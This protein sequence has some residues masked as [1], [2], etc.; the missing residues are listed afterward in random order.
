MEGRGILTNLADDSEK[1]FFFFVNFTFPILKN[2][3]SF[4]R[5]VSINLLIYKF[6]FV[7]CQFLSR[8]ISLESLKIIKNLLV[9]S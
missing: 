6:L 8:H 1:E 9:L 5:K 3:N 7:T 4:K 2:I